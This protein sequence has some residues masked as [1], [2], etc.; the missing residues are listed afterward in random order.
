MQSLIQTH[1]HT[2]EKIKTNEQR[3]KFNKIVQFGLYNQIG[4]GITLIHL[5]FERNEQINRE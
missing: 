5:H 1:A 2:L 3:K 4:N